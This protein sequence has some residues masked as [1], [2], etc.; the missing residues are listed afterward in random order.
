MVRGLD[1]LESNKHKHTLRSQ[2]YRI[3]KNAGKFP[4]CKGTYPDC[5][6]KPDKNN[7]MC[8]NCPILADEDNEDSEKDEI[9]E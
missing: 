2:E 1:Q 4:E 8:R 7:S 3:L 5:P 6:E 9:D